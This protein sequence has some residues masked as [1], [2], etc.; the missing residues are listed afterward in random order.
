M[1]GGTVV[2]NLTPKCLLLYFK[3][4]EFRNLEGIFPLLKL[5]L[6]ETRNCLIAIINRNNLVILKFREKTQ[7]LSNL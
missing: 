7:M 5:E 4:Y 2:Q 6:F 3:A 1:S